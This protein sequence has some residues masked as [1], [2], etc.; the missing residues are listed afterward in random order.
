MD[1]C[2]AIDHEVF[3]DTNSVVSYPLFD[4]G[5]APVSGCAVMVNHFRNRAYPADLGVHDDNE[6]FYVVEGTGKYII[7]GREYDLRAGTSM[8]A[9]AGMP[10]GLKNTGEGPLVVFIYHFPATEAAR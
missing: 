10:H 1:Y 7:R 3:T 4:A 2:A 6:G 9:P 5:N 8:F